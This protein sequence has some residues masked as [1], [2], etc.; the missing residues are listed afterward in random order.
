VTRVDFYVLEAPNHDRH[1]RMICRVVEKAWQQGRTLYLACDDESTVRAYDAMLWQFQDTSFVPHATC[2]DADARV[3]IVI[4]CA[5]R[6]PGEADVLV[7]LGSAVPD[8]VS[9]YLHVIESAGHDD[10]TRAR[11][12]QRD[13]YYQER[14]FPLATHKVSA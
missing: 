2:F 4:G 5:P 12:R 10:D 1:Q 11:A 6:P 7:N 14:G 13:R 9:R 8:V 3:P